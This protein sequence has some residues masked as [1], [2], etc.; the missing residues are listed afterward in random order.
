MDK[1]NITKNVSASLVK[2]APQIFTG[3]TVV[4]VT[5]TAI[6]A[7]KAS[8]KARDILDKYIEDQEQENKERVAKGEDPFELRITWQDRVRLT[9]RLYVPTILAGLYTV[10]CAITSQSISTQRNAAL[11]SAYTLAQ[12]TAHE[13]QTKVI[14]TMGEKKE[15]AVHDAIAK[16]KV[17]ANPP[18]DG[19]IIITGRGETLVLDEWSG[20]YFKSDIEE[21]RKIQNLLNQ[22]IINDGWVSLSELYSELGLAHTTSSDDMGWTTDLLIDMRFSSQLTPDGEPCL[23]LGF[24]NNPQ[25]GAWY[26]H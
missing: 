5:A 3:M 26:G 7:A 1:E 14:E 9:W 13:Y 8:P 18:Q 11:L 2:Y 21:L 19:Q 25:Y 4:G 6:F 12:A 15:L 24:N 17:I 10:T 20:R 16:D 22:R 23:V